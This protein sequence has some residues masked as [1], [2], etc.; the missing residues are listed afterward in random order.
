MAREH[1]AQRQAL[2]AAAVPVFAERGLRGATIRGIARRAGVNSA[3]LYYYF[4]DKEGL[5]AEAVR[6]VLGGFLAHLDARRPAPRGARPRLAWLVDGIFGYYTAHPERMRLMITALD[7]HP[8]L[9][10]RALKAFLRG[11]RLAPLEVLAAGVRR[12]ELRRAH[13]LEF[14]WS[15]LSL[16]LFSLL[17]QPVVRRLKLPGRPPAAGGLAARREQILDLLEHGC[18]SQRSAT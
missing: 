7:L 6:F 2:L 10:G 16:C 13:P 4:R 18:A 15:I 9:I 12:G 14:W 3:L 11:R 17:L 1:S 8:E 5:F